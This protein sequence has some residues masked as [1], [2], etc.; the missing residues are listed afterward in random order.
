M[1]SHVF[2]AHVG[3]FAVFLALLGLIPLVGDPAGAFWRAHPEF[4]VFPLQTVLCGTLLVCWRGAYEFRPFGTSDRTSRWKS[5][6]SGKIKAESS[7]QLQSRAGTVSYL[8]SMGRR[9]SK[10]PFSPAR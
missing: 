7:P 10:R 9:T 6:K 1:R 8:I 5:F 2:A 3:P 4:W